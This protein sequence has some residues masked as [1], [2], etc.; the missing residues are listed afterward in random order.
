MKKC[1]WPN[2]CIEV[3]IDKEGADMITNDTVSTLDW[4]I[5]MRRIGFSRM[6]L[7]VMIYKHVKDIRITIKLTTLVHEYILV[8]HERAMTLQPF[9]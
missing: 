5:L 2:F 3:S 4:S 8:S 9:A 6:N 1:I 7:I